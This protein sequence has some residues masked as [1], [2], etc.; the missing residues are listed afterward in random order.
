MEPSLTE[1]ELTAPTPVILRI[2]ADLRDGDR[3]VL[4]VGPADGDLT[5]AITIRLHIA[6]VAEAGLHT[7]QALSPDVLA[8]LRAGDEFQA[9]YN[10]A[11]NFLAVRPRSEAEVRRRLRLKTV[12][13]DMI[14]AVVARLHHARYL[15]DAE[16]ARYWLAERARTRPRG[17]RLLRGELR[18]KGVASTLIDQAVADFEET[19]AQAAVEEAAARAALP[20]TADAAD[21]A[22]DPFADAGRELREALILAER[23]ARSYAALD[24][25]T[26][27]RRLSGFLLR[28]GYGYDVVSKV[29]KAV[30][31]RQPVVGNE[32]ADADDVDIED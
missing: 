2:E 29:V 5:Q 20:A 8:R 19:A 23:K 17:I 16:F 18:E 9:H 1:V 28:R 26:F 11:L 6:V 27:R 7:G 21:P 31:S 22:E 14:D 13:P 3:V 24:P 30:G 12:P 32:D 25:P 15:D 4:T 10:R